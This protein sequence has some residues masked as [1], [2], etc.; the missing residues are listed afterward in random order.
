MTPKAKSTALILS[1]AV[2]LSFTAYAIGSQT[3]DGSAGAQSAAAKSSS[4]TATARPA[5]FGPGFGPALDDLADTLGVSTSALQQ[6]FED[7]RDE[8]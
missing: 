3:G 6:A 5:D 8:L 7:A 4:S 1:G 2:A